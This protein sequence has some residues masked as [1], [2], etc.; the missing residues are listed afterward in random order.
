MFQDKPDWTEY[1]RR[2]WTRSNASLYLRPD[3]RL[4]LQPN[5]K[6]YFKPQPYERKDHADPSAELEELHRLKSELESLK[7]EIK[8]RRLL[9][10]SKAYDPNQP[11][12]PAG[13]REGGQWTNGDAGTGVRVASIGRT[14]GQLLKAALRLRLSPPDNATRRAR[15]VLS[16][17]RHLDPL[18]Q[19]KSNSDE[20]IAQEAEN[21]LAKFAD[22]PPD[23]LIATYRAQNSM[24]DLF[25]QPTWRLDKGTV[26]VTKLDGV[27]E[28]GVNSKA[29]GY[30]GKDTATAD[31]MRR[32]LIE[33][34]PEDMK[35]S[36]NIGRMPNDSVYHAE[37]TVLF[38][39]ARRYGGTLEGRTLD[40]YVDREMCPS[41]DKALPLIGQELGNPTIT[42]LDLRSG[43]TATMRDGKW[44]NRTRP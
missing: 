41:C 5:Q 42:Y 7:A 30:E 3:P 38:R 37:A 17:V 34:Y 31:T 26:A 16:R 20:G 43:E 15:D 22:L 2:R 44:I 36:N 18:R 40:V 39:A 13:S 8:F 6:L 11:R 12:V 9:R 24:P 27:P 25:G 29:P 23:R 14:I 32:L 4:Y 21:R 19:P 1:Q 35:R 33:T 28:F 10:E